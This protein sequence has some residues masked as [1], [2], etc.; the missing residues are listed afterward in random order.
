MSITALTPISAVVQLT[1]GRNTTNYATGHEPAYTL[2]NDLDTYWEPASTADTIVYYD[3]GASTTPDAIVFWIRNYNMLHHDTTISS[4]KH[5]FNVYYSTDDVTYTLVDTCTMQNYV[6]EDTHNPL[7]VYTLPSPIN[8]RYWALEQVNYD[9]APTDDLVLQISGVWF[10]DSHTLPYRQQTQMITTVRHH[11]TQTSLR[12]G[13]RFAS[14]KGLGRQQRF[15][16]QYI[17]YT[18]TNQWSVLED[19]YEATRGG[20]LP[21]FMQQSLDDDQYR[22]LYFDG[23]LT[24]NEIDYNYRTPRVVLIEPGYERVPYQNR[25]LVPFAQTVGLWRFRGNGVDSSS[26][27]NNLTAVNTPTFSTGG[28]TEHGSTVVNVAPPNSYRIVAASASD[29]DMGTDDFTV[30]LWVQCTAALLSDCVRKL[31]G[32]PAAG[33]RVL[34]VTDPFRFRAE[35]GDG[36]NTAAVTSSEITELG[37]WLHLACVVNRTVNTCTLYRNGVSFGTGSIAAI[38]GN[39]TNAARNFDIATGGSAILLD[40]VCIT[41]RVLTT[42]ELLARFNGQTDY[43]TWGM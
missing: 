27:G 7:V 14:H 22:M 25:T 3:L 5:S 30:E 29:F 35:M 28:I 26:G 9:H 10:C 41:R 31:S 37:E 21:F 40:E 23:P 15:D 20:L 42:N 18:D 34:F 16:Q 39:I 17:F 4:N 2:D 43:G 24:P 33:W 1:S 13:V 12:S 8:A 6:Q 19:I 11:N 32:T 36:V 38:T